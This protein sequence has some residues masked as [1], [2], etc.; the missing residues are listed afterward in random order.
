MLDA[1]AE[2]G[3]HGVGHVERVL[4][5]EED[6]DALAAH[7]PHDQLDALEQHLRRL[8]EEQVRLVEEEHQL[9]LVEVAD[10][11]QLLVQLGEH[12]EQEGRVQA[13]AGHQLVGGEDVDHALLWPFIDA[14]CMKSAM[15][16][17]GSPKNLSPPWASICSRP[18][19]IA[20]T[21]AA[22]TLP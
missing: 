17:I 18:R 14:V 1:V 9:G 4:G 22:L 16:S 8:V 13:R 7:Q 15:S 19:W 21:L 5:H 3:Q 11:G 20:P 10:L 2:L 12:P 6:A